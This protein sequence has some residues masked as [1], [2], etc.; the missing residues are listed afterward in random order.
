[1][2]ITKEEILPNIYHVRFQS[3]DEQNHTL[4]RFQEYYES[5]KFKGKV[6]TFKQFTKWYKTNS[7]LNYFTYWKGFNFPSSNLKPFREGKFKLTDNEMEFL[8]L[9]DD[10]NGKF[11]IISLLYN[12]NPKKI[13]HEIAHAFYYLDSNYK[14]KVNKVLSNLD[15][16]TKTKL[17]KYLTEEMGYHSSVV[18]DESHAYLLCES[19]ELKKETKIDRDKIDKYNKMLKEIY[20]SFIK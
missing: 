10:M 9:F 12:V 18:K 16:D 1:M 5:P 7:K 13:N 11:Y 3:L 19:D 15:K 20:Q 8:K 17:E 2:K 6:F 14:D 4:L